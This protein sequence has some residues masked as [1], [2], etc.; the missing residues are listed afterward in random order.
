MTTSIKKVLVTGASSGIG[1]QL[2]KDYLAE[3]WLV[4]A[5]GRNQQALS[6]ISGAKALVFDITDNAAVK[7]QAQSLIARGFDGFDL[8]ILNAGSCEYIDDAHQFDAELFERVIRTNLIAMGY[9]LGAFIP[10]IKSGGRLGLMGS[11]AVYLPFSRAEAYGASKAGVQYLA[12]SLAI[13]L[14]PHNIGVSVICPGFVKTPLTDK[15]D[16]AMPMQQTSEQASVAIR[17][18]LSKGVREIHFP[19][20]FTLLLKFI[21]LLPRS[22]WERINQTTPADT[23]A[24]LPVHSD[25]KAS[26]PTVETTDNHLKN[27]PEEAKKVSQ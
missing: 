17:H 24:D 20:R 4:Y 11:S 27:K 1:L 14:K 6:Q 26:P 19:K 5:C 23:A 10:L 21:S 15:N 13:D 12:S 22:L 25:N 2:A 16:F 9:C 8:V 7:A 3:G 18:G